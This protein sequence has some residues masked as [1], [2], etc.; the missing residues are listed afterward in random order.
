MALQ[1]PL[2]IVSDQIEQLQ[3]GDTINSPGGILAFQSNNS[4]AGNDF[5]S[6]WSGSAQGTEGV[7]AKIIVPGPT[8]T[9]RTIK[10]ARAV[11]TS[12]P[13]GV[14]AHNFTVR[15]NGVNT[16]L[17]VIITDA[18]TSGSDVVNSFTAL[19]GDTITVQYTKTGS[20]AA[21]GATMIAMEL[22]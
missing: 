9:D 1:K 19:P 5:L 3:T 6:A 12:A 22:Q 7:Q 20:P 16:T 14:T 21:A 17:I 11:V 8:G 15:K 2:V 18:T 4:P 13:G 10:N